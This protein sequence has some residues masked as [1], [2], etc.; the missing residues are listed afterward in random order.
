[1]SSPRPRLSRSESLHQQIA[2]QLRNEIT[3][4]VWQDGDTLPS[5]R[6]MAT[7]WNVSV[8]TINEAMR[9][10]SDQGLVVSKSRSKRVVRL[11]DQ[12]RR[13]P[14][15]LR[16]PNVIVVGGYAGSGKTELG[17]ILARATG[18][19]ILDKDSL[20]RPVVE[21]AL[22][23]MGL[24][25]HDRESEAYLNVIRPREYE[26]LMDAAE[27]NVECGN[28]AIVTAPFVRELRD[29]LWVSR[30]HS[31]FAS[32]EAR[33]HLVWVY[34]DAQTMQTY[35]RRRGA[36]RDAAKLASWPEYLA[37]V[38]TAFRPSAEHYLI[39]NCVSAD[40]LLEQANEV[41]KSIL[42]TEPA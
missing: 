9:V 37:G 10:L 1:M 4:G 39:D 22:E 27:E 35:I 23:V 11:P 41:L 18:W 7:Q 31:R 26:A 32:M 15:R 40:P 36:A 13:S 34:C 16:R 28:S 12:E 42:G 24:S 19:A 2:R 25:P 38:D 14:V 33:V 3:A 21:A 8:F 5:S 20:T 6:D 29:D 30:M 17:R